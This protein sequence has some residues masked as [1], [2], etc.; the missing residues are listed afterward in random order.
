MR[1]EAAVT[2]AR[3]ATTPRPLPEL[4]TSVAP[5]SSA[6]SSSINSS[7]TKMPG[8][9]LA[10]ASSLSTIYHALQNARTPSDDSL[11]P[12]P[13]APDA[14]V[15]AFDAELQREPGNRVALVSAIG[16]LGTLALAAPPGL[17]AVLDDPTYFVRGEALRALSHFSG[18]VDRA[19]PVLLNDMV[20]NTDRVLPDY[21]AIAGEMHPSAA[22]VPTLLRALESDDGLVREAAATLLG[23][24][25]PRPRSAAPAVVALMKKTLSISEGPGGGSDDDAAPAQPRGLA[26]KSGGRPPQPAPG[27]VS[28]D[29]AV[30][31][32]RV[33]PPEEA[34]PLLM[35]LLKRRSRSA[36]VAGAAG[37]EELGPAAHTA[38]PA[39]VANLKAAIA[40]DDRQA[41]SDV[42]SRTAVAL[43][44][45]APGAP[46]AKA[47]SGEVV[48]VLTEAVNVPL[49]PFRL[50][51]VKALGNF[52]P[53]AA[54][55][56]PSLRKLLDDEN[57]TPLV[58]EAAEAAL[59]KIEPQPKPTRSASR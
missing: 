26:P 43:G 21:A 42:G 8:C 16:N 36:R 37:L 51:A 32:A 6:S 2:L 55:A 39:L 35:Q 40:A 5:E 34:L 22:V 17:L 10:M 14:L 38:I 53:E 58:K 4:P 52:G 1:I 12:D 15:A 33:A 46:D 27:S 57:Q 29:L 25:E 28:N 54:P 48:E 30:A 45:I 41:V 59:Q 11:G 9:A 44:R 18:G 56:I 50:P 49:L 20:K 47:T 31:L 24:I 3:L 23:R 13:L 19:I 7:T